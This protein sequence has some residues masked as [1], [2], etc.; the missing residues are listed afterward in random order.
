MPSSPDQ[1][2]PKECRFFTLTPLVDPD[3]IN[4]DLT[5]QP[6]Q[7]LLLLWGKALYLEGGEDKDEDCHRGTWLMEMECENVTWIE[8]RHYIITD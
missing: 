6:K 4:P 8:V 1:P 7:K 5:D 2:W 3:T